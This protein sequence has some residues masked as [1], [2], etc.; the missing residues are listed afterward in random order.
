MGAARSRAGGL[1]AMVDAQVEWR[2]IN[3]QHATY[4]NWRPCPPTRPLRTER[5]LLDA[6]RC[7]A[8]LTLSKDTSDNRRAPHS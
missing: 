3:V 1:E 2:I 4:H 8:D 7:N 6:A 5:S